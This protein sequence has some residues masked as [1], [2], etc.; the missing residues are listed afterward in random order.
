MLI[1]SILLIKILISLSNFFSIPILPIII[2]IVIFVLIKLIIFLFLFNYF[3]LSN[4]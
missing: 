1:I 2:T 4:I 3:Y